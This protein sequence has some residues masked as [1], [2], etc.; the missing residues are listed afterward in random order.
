MGSIQSVCLLVDGNPLSA[1]G[2]IDIEPCPLNHNTLPLVLVNHIHSISM[3]DHVLFRDNIGVEVGIG[4][5]HTPIGGV[6]NVLA[7]HLALI[8]IVGLLCLDV[9]DHLPLLL[10][11]NDVGIDLMNSPAFNAVH[12]DFVDVPLFPI[13]DIV[14][15][16]L[17]LVVTVVVL[18][19]DFLETLDLLLPCY[20]LGCDSLNTLGLN[21]PVRVIICFV[22]N[23]LNH[24]AGIPNRVC[25][26]LNGLLLVP[27]AAP[28]M[29]MGGVCDMPL[30]MG[31][32]GEVTKDGRLPFC[33]HDHF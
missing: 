27:E 19:G 10:V 22:D 24:F 13:I 16:H 5:E 30:H 29:M 17:L 28:S 8:G 9:I 18:E 1:F 21:E 15:G 33:L 26:L 23:L 6:G 32:C 12:G 3:V 2:D 31:F 11:D 25:N 7:L 20:E 14:C 4:I